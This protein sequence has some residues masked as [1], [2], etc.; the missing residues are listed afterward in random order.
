MT[1]PAPAYTTRSPWWA[2]RLIL[3]I[4]AVCFLFSALT[5]GGNRILSANAYEW[6]A[7]GFAAWVFSGVLP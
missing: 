2:V 3:L 1:T 5:F 4:S 7:A 6:L